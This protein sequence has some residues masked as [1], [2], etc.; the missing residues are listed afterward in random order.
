MY[1]VELC[2]QTFPNVIIDHVLCVH[3]H[4]SG[5]CISVINRGVSIMIIDL[6]LRLSWPN[7]LL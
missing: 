2:K 4:V 1:Y 3:V 5:K 7:G 6:L